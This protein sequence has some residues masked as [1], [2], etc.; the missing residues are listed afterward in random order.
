MRLRWQISII[1][2]LGL[3]FPLV[4][5]WAFDQLNQTYQ[6]GMVAAAQKQ[7]DVIKKSVQQYAHN[8]G[9]EGVSGLVPV[10]LGQDSDNEGDFSEWNE[11]PWYAADDDL[12]FKLGRQ[13]T[14]WRLMV[15][16]MDASPRFAADGSMD[17]LI[18]ATGNPQGIK[19]HTI[20]RQAEGAVFDPDIR[21]YWHEISGGYQVELTLPDQ[22]MTRLGLA[23]FDYGAGSQEPR[24][25]GHVNN[26]QIQLQ[27]LFEA[28]SPWQEL[29][30]NIKPQDGQLTLT[31]RQGRLLYASSPTPASTK[32]SDWLSQFLYEQIFDNNPDD[33]SHFYGQTLQHDLPFGVLHSTFNQAQAQITLM[34]T[35]L[36]TLGWV[37]LAALVLIVGSF[38]YAVLLAWRIKKIQ[39][40]LQQAMSE[41]GEL[42]T[43]LPLAGSR[44]E[45]GKLSRDMGR[46]LSRITDYTGYLKQLGSR[47]S[48]EMKT[49]I[50]IV[51]T[52][53][54]NLQLNHPDDAF[55]GR[56]LNANNRLKFILNQ[57][58][59]LSRLKQAIADAETHDIDLSDLIKQLAAGY[60]MNHDQIETD[61][62]TNRIHI[63]G[64]S[65]LLAQMLDKLVHNATTFTEANDRIIIALSKQKQNAKLRVS[66]TGSS[67]DDDSKHH[68][69][70]SLASFRSQPSDTPHLGL[71]LYIAQLITDHHQGDIDAQN[72]QIDGR[73][74]VCFTVTIPL[75]TK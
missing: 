9:L 38:L 47:L 29:L 12:Q 53:L 10:D 75:L 72:V 17:R 37:L 56:A 11:V 41:R 60:Q 4:A 27:A 5:W 18:I 32:D 8:Q 69:F 67:I 43:H 40:G 52:S 55:V 48:H 70:D 64:N 31:D 63:Q 62:E 25:H 36:K 1:A 6:D 7:A 50:S 66:N 49:P 58:S 15:Q 3:C 16:C 35:F 30:E 51:H 61:I 2:L 57:L 71:G 39:K 68:L 73:A 28:A 23:V 65:E 45:L 59:A 42:T 20:P 19:K 22:H 33:P 21:G 54:E 46:L 34:Q 24:H 13:G 74:G 14:Q 26:Q 44:D